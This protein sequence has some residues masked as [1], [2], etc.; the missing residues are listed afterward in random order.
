[1]VFDQPDDHKKTGTFG[2]DQIAKHCRVR[3]I[4][5]LIAYFLKKLDSMF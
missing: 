3:Y 1:M 5:V 4:C 2:F